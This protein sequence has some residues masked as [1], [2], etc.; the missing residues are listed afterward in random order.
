MRKTT[1]ICDRCGREDGDCNPI[2][3]EGVT[4]HKVTVDAGMTPIFRSDL[5]HECYALLMARL[6]VLGEDFT[7]YLRKGKALGKGETP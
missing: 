5:C 1:I 6:E 2:I 4:E 7:S 3:G